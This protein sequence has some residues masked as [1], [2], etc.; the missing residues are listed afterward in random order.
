MSQVVHV[1]GAGISGLSLAYELAKAGFNVHVYDKNNRVGG[2]INTLRTPHGLV[3]TAANSILVSP[4][5][6]ALLKEVEAPI[7][8]PQNFAKKRYLF[9]GK[10]TRWPLP[11][12][13]TLG[14]IKRVFFHL[15]TKKKDLKPRP[16]ETL[17]QWGYRC[18]GKN[19]TD[20]LVSPAMQGIYA[21]PAEELSASLLLSGLFKKNRERSLGIISGAQGMKDIMDS[22]QR[23]CVKKGVQFHL[24]QAVSLQELQGPIVIATSA[25]DAQILLKDFEPESA[26]QLAQIPLNNVTS[27][28]VFF[29]KDS[30]TLPG[31]GCLIPNR[32]GLKTLGVLFNPYIFPNRDQMPNETYILGGIEHPEV[33]Q[34][35][36]EKICE[37]IEK[38]SLAIFG[39][40]RKIVDISVHKWEQV[41]P[42]YSVSLEKLLPELKLPNNIFLHGN[43]LG[44]I[45]MSKIIER[46]IELAQV[47]KCKVDERSL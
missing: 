7:V 47:L 42:H 44:G 10:P 16:L 25:A 39:N 11:L 32:F 35:T 12:L 46:S 30:P 20:L 13:D 4:T 22:F 33:I 2:L 6:L 9:Y 23:A 40:S 21:S 18:L 24:A 5:T 3:E 8:H 1:V 26:K 29:E 36:D 19:A 37:L 43:Y 15:L 28:T 27:A 38:E 31:F 14:L 17:Q 45:G 41:L 34:L